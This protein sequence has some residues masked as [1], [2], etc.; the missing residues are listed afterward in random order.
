MKLWKRYWANENEK[1][2]PLSQTISIIREK[3]IG[4]MLPNIMRV[5][6]VLLV[7][8]ATSAGVERS[9]LALRYIKKLYRNSMSESRFNALILMYVHRYIE[10]DY[11][12]IIDFFA[13]KHPRKMLLV[14]PE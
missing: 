2:R 8:P 1:P 4:K 13:T 5:F 12:K 3:Q 11:D 9:I 10:L 14:L 6:E 7:I